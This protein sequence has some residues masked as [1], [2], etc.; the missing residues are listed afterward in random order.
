MA[1]TDPRYHIVTINYENLP[2]L[3]DVFKKGTLPFYGLVLDEVDKMK[4]PGTARF[5]KLRHRIFE[6]EWRVVMTGTPTPESLLNLWAPVYLAT[7]ETDGGPARAAL[8][9]SYTRFKSQYFEN[10]DHNGYKQKPRPGAIR[11]IASKIAPYVF[12]ARAEDHLDVPPLVVDDRYFTLPPKARDLYTTF[13]RDLV[14]YLERGDVLTDDTED[15]DDPTAVAENAAVL[16]N[17]LRQICSG[18][19]YTTKDEIRSTTWLHTEKLDLYKGLMSELMGQQVLVVYGY[20]AEYEK[21][22]LVD[23]LGGGISERREMEILRAWNNREIQVLG[24]HPASAGHGLNLHESGACH[25]VFLS[26]PWSRGLYDQT[27]GRLRRM[28]QKKNVIVHRL[29]AAGTVER[30]VLAALQ[31]KGDVQASV[32]EALRNRK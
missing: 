22:G 4:D 11:T 26:L 21:F 25:M 28:G 19:V 15:W 8:G 24:M 32:L 13:E 17:K 5:R 29:F 31:A 16:K 3:L 7:A 14:L 18:F 9:T 6:F 2:W 30:D 27:L 20:Q 23:R 1:L 12:Q 10:V